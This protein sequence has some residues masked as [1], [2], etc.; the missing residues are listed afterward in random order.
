M[1][2]VVSIYDY[3]IVL[4]ILLNDNHDSNMSLLQ[5]IKTGS[6][7]LP[8]YSKLWRYRE[9]GSFEG[10]YAPGTLGFHVSE[11]DGTGACS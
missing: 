11:F 7:I 1:Y 6:I 5:S 10:K 2:N 3:T 4:F 9:V 8:G